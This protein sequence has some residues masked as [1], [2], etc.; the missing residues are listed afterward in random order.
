[1]E[2]SACSLLA[3]ID[4]FQSK[5]NQPLPPAYAKSDPFTLLQSTSFPDYDRYKIEDLR[6]FTGPDFDVARAEIASLK[7]ADEKIR[8]SA[9]VLLAGVIAL[10]TG[11]DAIA[12]SK[13]AAARS[14][15]NEALTYALK[16]TGRADSRCLGDND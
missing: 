2:R 11:E 15:A 8:V 14:N 6:G 5:R 12:Q 4:H 10:D 1:V 9:N 7:A 3:E 13:F 16:K